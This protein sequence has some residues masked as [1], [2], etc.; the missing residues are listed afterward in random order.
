MNHTSDGEFAYGS[1]HINPVNATKPGLVYEILENDYVNML[2]AMG[3]AQSSLRLIS[4][5]NNVTCNNTEASLKHSSPRDLNYPSMTAKVLPTKPF[6]IKFTRRV[7]N[8]G[9]ANSTYKANIFQSTNEV[10]VK[11]TPSV[12]SFKSLNEEK[13][14][15]VSVVGRGLADGSVV[16]AS[17]VWS[18]GE[19]IVRSPI[20]VYT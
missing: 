14:F 4:G 12:V 10:G 9:L 18:D 5:D 19:H 11:V 17:F 3:Y 7:K 6:E 16:S 1:G 8:V 20:V 2:C 13:A 15:E